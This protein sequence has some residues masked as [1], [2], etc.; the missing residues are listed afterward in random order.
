[1]ADQRR[2]LL[3]VLV[4]L[5]M[6]SLAAHA[7]E[8]DVYAS[9]PV[10]R[11]VTVYRAPEGQGNLQLADLE[12][13]ALIT[14]TRTVSL[15]AGE[16]RLRFP[17]VADGIE[18]RSAIVTGLPQGVL[19]KNRDAQV[20]SP[21]ALVA[22]TVGK[23]LFL[24]RTDRKSG[25]PIRIPGTLRADNDG[26]VFQSSEGLEALRCSGLPE[27]FTFTSSADLAPTPTLSVK[28][29]SEVALTATVTLSYLAEGFDWAATY[30]AALSADGR[31]LDLGAWLTLAN[32]NGISFPDSDVAVV[33]GRINVGS[34]DADEPLRDGSNDVARC[35]PV[36]RTSDIPYR[37]PPSREPD[38]PLPLEERLAARM[39]LPAS[40][41]S[42]AQE[43]PLGDLKLY[44]VPGRT[45]VS[46]RQMKQVRLLDR[47]AVPVELLHVAELTAGQTAALSAVRVLRTRNDSEHHL[48]LP[49]P[50]GTVATY[51]AAASAPI[52]TATPTAA[53]TPM[54]LEESPLRDIAVNEVFEI[55]AGEAADVQVRAVNEDTLGPQSI[56]K[57]PLLPGVLEVQTGMQ[58]Q[59]SRID[60]TSA[61]SSAA[62]FEARLDLEEGWELVR[63]T[64]TPVLRDGLQVMRIEI[65]AGGAVTIRYQTRHRL[66]RAARPR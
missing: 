46:A 60:I 55:G 51:A 11:T 15:P 32:S 25:R 63:S 21:K 18:S 24:V 19:E 8:A 3:C 40:V 37:L 22:A 33:A 45:T 9:P 16:S 10:A 43:E 2:E 26:V 66:S 38:R 31:T 1:M 23:P 6:A 50:Q 53:P 49:L 41:V 64:V 35:W 62:A 47:E 36:K 61:R 56:R 4:A 5:R 27:T 30:T 28:V 13:L 52:P 34:D 44:R 42:D 59:V 14:E 20:L 54:L 48:G 17:S 58:T 65:P 29:R 39:A 7:Q 12:G 57:I